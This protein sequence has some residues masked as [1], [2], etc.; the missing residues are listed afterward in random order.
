LLGAVRGYGK[1]QVLFAGFPPDAVWRRVVLQPC[2][3]ETMRYARHQTW[4]TISK[5]TRL[6]SV[7]ARTLTEEGHSAETEQ[8]TAIANAFRNGERFADLIAAEDARGLILIE[9]HSRATAYFQV[10]LIDEVQ[11]LV[12]SSQSMPKWAFY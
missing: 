5:G 8:V 2:D 7:G 6:V 11:C 4:T 9:G 12:A 3:F 1:N 10:G